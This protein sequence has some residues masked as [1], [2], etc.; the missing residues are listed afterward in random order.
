MTDENLIRFRATEHGCTVFDVEDF[1][2]AKLLLSEI[3]ETGADR[4]EVKAE[5]IGWAGPYEILTT[6]L[7]TGNQVL[8]FI[9]GAGGVTALLY[10]F[11]TRHPEKQIQ[12]VTDNR[13]IVVNASNPPTEEESTMINEFFRSNTTT[14]SETSQ[15]YGPGTN[16]L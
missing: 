2:D 9:N 6:I 10:S 13:T 14:P 5:H 16:T 15:F 11:I 12:V 1:Q 7:E 8:G 4:F 3:R